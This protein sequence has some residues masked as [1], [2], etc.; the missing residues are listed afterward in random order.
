MRI[1]VVG[2]GIAGLGA[3]WAL[4]RRHHVTLYEADG[5]L[6]GHSNT[7][8][9]QDAERAVPVDTGFIVYNEPNYPNL[10]RLFEALGVATEPS[11]MS[12]SVSI[13]GFEY[14]GRILGLLAPRNL[15]R[16]AHLRMVADI[17]RF[18]RDAPRLLASGSGESTGEF[19]DRRGYG[20]AFRRRYLLPMVACI[21]SS[22]LDRML[23]A[24]ARMLFRFL[25]NHGLL[26][27]AGRPRWRTVTGG[28][29]RYVEGMAAALDVVKTGTRVT[30]VVRRPHEVWVRDARGGAGRFDHVV[31]AS[32]ADSSLRILGADA[33]AE[34]VEILGAFRYQ[35]NRAVLHHDPSLMPAR[36]RLWSSWNYLDHGGSGGRVSLTYW[37]NR[38][39]N[40]RTRRPVLETLNPSREPADA[41]SEHAYRHPQFDRA[42]VDAQGRIET[43]QGVSRT[44]FCGSYCGYGFHE[45]GLRAGLE[46]AAALGS[47]APW[48]KDGER[49]QTAVPARLEANR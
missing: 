37:M 27:A 38:L 14:Q 49:G 30:S 39:Q 20:P 44:W 21:W 5:R 13:G 22:S 17:L 2:S 48:W 1:A 15:A 8:E 9:I 10:V 29:R 25:D 46:V 7:V 42:A 35:E 4:T 11:E 19:L 12:F 32:H 33:S 16:P 41:V 43:I 45:D 40:L 3:A 28:S 23:E 31:L 18:S 36:R 26:R 34:E 6:G 24:P 47:S